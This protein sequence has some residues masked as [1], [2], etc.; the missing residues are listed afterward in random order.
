MSR[1]IRLWAPA[2]VWMS[3]L[4]YLSSLSD[5]LPA[6]LS[7]PDYYTHGAAYAVLAVLA[8][9]ALA[10]GIGRPFKAAAGVAT[11]VLC[12]LYGVSDEYHQSF[13]P[14]RDASVGDVAKDL[15]GAILGA[16][17]LRWRSGR[18]RTEKEATRS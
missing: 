6:G 16:A 1:A 2:V 17:L 12:T 3:V 13:V 18:S 4:F 11:V 9:R 14:G 15:G 8:G 7:V 10:G 5:P